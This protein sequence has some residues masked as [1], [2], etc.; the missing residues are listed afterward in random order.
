M[1]LVQGMKNKKELSAFKKLIKNLYIEL[2]HINNKIS[3]QACLY[4]EKFYLSNSFELADA[5]IAAT[6]ITY[7]DVLC[8]AND[9]H[10]KVVPDLDIDVFR[11]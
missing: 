10:Y 9:K 7:E 3:E 11:P 5:L 2:I 8:T 6:C 4:V 1:E